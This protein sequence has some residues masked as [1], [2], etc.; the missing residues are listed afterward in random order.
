M[1]SLLSLIQWFGVGE[2]V[3]GVILT[4]FGDLGPTFSDFLR[5]WKD[6]GICID[7]VWFPETPGSESTTKVGG[8][9]SVQPGTKQQFENIL[10][11]K[12]RL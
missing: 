9:M 4:P 12:Y 1:I 2:V 8:K 11:L 7:L 3:L 6:I 5:Y 10:A